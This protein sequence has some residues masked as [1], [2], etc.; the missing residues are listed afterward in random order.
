MAD[1]EV[2]NKLCIREFDTEKDV[3]RVE[4]L[5]MRCEVG[6]STSVSLYTD[7]MGDPICRIRHSPAYT[8]LVAEYGPDR[9]MV[10]IIRGSIK[11]V[12]CGINNQ[13][14][15]QI[16]LYT[17]AAYIL[18][19]RVSPTH[20]RKGIGL[21]LVQ[22]IEKWFKA[23]GAEYAYM[24]TEKDN[25]AC[26]KLF[27]EKCSFTKF[28]TPAMLVHPV[29]S[30]SKH[31][32]SS[33]KIL[34]LGMKEAEALYRRCMGTSEFFPQDIDTILQNK[35]SLGTWVAFPRTEEWPRATSW[36]VL[37][38]WSSNDLFKM[39]VKGVCKTKRM[40]AAATRLLDKAFPWLNVPSIPDVF[41]PFGIHF[42]YGLHGEGPKC[43]KLM[44]CLW[45]FT[46]NLA[47]EKKG[48]RF[49]A[50]EVGARDPL[51]SWIPYRDLFS[52]PEDLWCIKKLS[53]SGQEDWSMSAP[54]L[55]LF[56][57]PREF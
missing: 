1:M 17:K 47:R 14:L 9:E 31:I 10:G 28:R 4:E 50:T 22:E 18:G 30:H 20:R 12:V 16:P 54:G 7:L 15:Q 41:R 2:H 24:A 37:S 38:V 36:A 44:S 13:E 43:G 19:L 34:K 40:Y 39:Q 26:I 6:S 42:L 45:W 23:N 21:R 57:D 8:M 11:T 48:C 32:S 55:R 46:H 35:L 53:S 3:E 33:V 51:M 5:E 49:L 25:N 56:V 29:Q 27:V 52:C